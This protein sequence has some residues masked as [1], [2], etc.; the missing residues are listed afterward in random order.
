[1]GAKVT[2]ADLQEV[3]K[4]GVDV[5]GSFE[6]RLGISSLSFLL[7]DM[8]LKDELEY[9]LDKGAM[10]EE[11]RGG[12]NDQTPLICAASHGHTKIVSLLPHRS[13]EMEAKDNRGS[14]PSCLDGSF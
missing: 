10:V 4:I 9:I 8:G 6:T 3:T 1:M 14:L 12:L 7:V 13:A 11:K 2:V 5:A